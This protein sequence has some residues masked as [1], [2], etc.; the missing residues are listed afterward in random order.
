MLSQ[1]A[2]R[3]AGRLAEGLRGAQWDGFCVRTAMLAEMDPAIHM[4]S[5]MAWDRGS[6]ARTAHDALFVT[7][8]GKQAAADRLWLAFGHLEE[9]AE[10]IA[11]Q[12]GEFAPAA[13]GLLARHSQKQPAPEWWTKLNEHYTQAMVEFYRSHDSAHP[14]ARKRLFYWAKRGEYVLE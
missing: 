2:A 1:S 14:R 11:A 6:T 8:T 7:T 4:L 5:R 3:R 12:P 10:L 9:A 13:R